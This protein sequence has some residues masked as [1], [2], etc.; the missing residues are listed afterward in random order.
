MRNYVI[1]RCNDLQTRQ[2]LLDAIK[3]GATMKPTKKGVMVYGPSGI[4][5]S[6]F[7]G[8]EYRGPKNLRSALR[9]AGLDV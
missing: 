7:T 1:R 9:R 6:H 4:V 3:A 8:G 5:A 2:V